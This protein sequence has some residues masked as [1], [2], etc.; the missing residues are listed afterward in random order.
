MLKI[1]GFN[2]PVFSVV[3]RIL[4]F[5]HLAWQNGRQNGSIEVALAECGKTRGNYGEN[6]IFFQ[7]L[8][9]VL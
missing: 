6:S 1:S 3:G 9:A 2:I 7:L 4:P 5:C 8:W